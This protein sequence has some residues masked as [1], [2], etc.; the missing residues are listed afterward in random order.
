M[1]KQKK[2]LIEEYKQLLLQELEEREKGKY[3]KPYLYLISRI[4]AFRQKDI[5]LQIFEWECIRVPFL[6][7]KHLYLWRT[8]L[9]NLKPFLL[10]PEYIDCHE[11][12]L[13]KSQKFF[14]DFVE[15]GYIFW[16]RWEY[17]KDAQEEAYRELFEIMKNVLLNYINLILY[18]KNNYEK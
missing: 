2:L 11:E 18:P 1:Y 6:K 9:Y 3:L 16:D 8:L 13:K 14:A 10:A 7:E 5:Y 4:K 12:D 17:L 15:R